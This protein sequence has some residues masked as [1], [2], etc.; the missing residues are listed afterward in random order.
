MTVKQAV[1]TLFA[2]HESL[3]STDTLTSS[4]ERLYEMMKQYQFCDAVMATNL[5]SIKVNYTCVDPGLLAHYP[6]T[7]IHFT[8]SIC[9]STI[10]L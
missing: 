9:Q 7:T 5:H 1:E 10:V 2:P 4:R 6:F 8:D 3:V